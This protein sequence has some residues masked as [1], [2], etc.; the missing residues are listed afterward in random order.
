MDEENKKKVDE[1]A[2]KFLREQA[3]TKA[4]FDNATL[5]PG[6]RPV[7]LTPPDEEPTDDQLLWEIITQQTNDREFN[8]YKEF[9]DAV[10]CG[11]K[12]D[13]VHDV[14]HPIL[15]QGK[16]AYKILQTLTEVFI[17]RNTKTIW[18]D[19]RD[20]DRDRDGDGNT[21][22]QAL[23]KVDGGERILPYLK[24]IRERL[25]GFDVKDE[26]HPVPDNCYGP[27]LSRLKYP[28]FIE[29][30]WNYWHEEAMVTQTIKAVALQ[31]QNR[32]L[33]PGYASIKHFQVDALRPLGNLLWGW[34]QDE[35]ERLSVS[36]RA[37][38]Y[39]H[40]YGLTLAGRAVRG[41]RPAETRSRFLHAFHELLHRTS[42]FY[43]QVDD[44]TRKADGFPLLNA[45]RELH[46]VLAEGAHNQF[47][48]LNVTARGETL[49]EMWLL[50][51]TEMREFFGQRIM[52][53]Y[54]EA[55]MDRVDSM[56]AHQGWSD[57]SVTHF[58]R[59]ASFG[60]RLILGARYGNWMNETEPAAAANWAKKWRSEVQGYTHAYQAVTGVNL[61]AREVRAAAI[62][63]TLPSQ[64]ITRRIEER[65]RPI[66]PARQAPALTA[67][68]A[69]RLR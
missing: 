25:E 21:Y 2:Q 60:E 48:D 61:A 26:H 10:F 64:L 34:I 16:G 27:L 54:P 57:A 44:M 1:A 22:L 4:H 8:R 43:E 53:P 56:K 47:A 37:H 65:R 29:L 24:V 14:K 69:T 58:Q 66:A 41:V 17:E 40:Q 12:D 49:I 6:I 46:I 18:D 52:V 35:Y 45:L 38:E 20:R 3:G 32:E 28:S 67:R 59:L 39:H 33:P 23:K 15:F 51:R 5:L 13:V 30:I 50:G 36:R 68:A 19:G 11:D 42:V 62:D 9:V 55:W 31:F 7:R 63:D